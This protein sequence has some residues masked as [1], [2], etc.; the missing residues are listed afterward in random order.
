MSSLKCAISTP[1]ALATEAGERAIEEGGNA[2]D[3]ALAAATMLTV[4]YPH[5]CAVGGDMFCL[6]RRPD[7]STISIDATGAAAA[8]RTS[9]ELIRSA[10]RMPVSGVETI[11]VP[12][13]V[14]GWEALFD[15]GGRLSISEPLLAA[16]GVAS[17]G[18]AV[19][20]SLARA[21]DEH[22][23]MIDADSGMR[24]VM[25]LEGSVRGEGQTLRQPRL[26]ATL[27][28]LAEQGSAALYGGA[29]GKRLIAGLRELGSALTIE[30]LRAHR[31]DI[32]AALSRSVGGVEVATSP[33]GSQGFVLLEIM[34]AIG[35]QGI[36]SGID[37][38]LLAQ[39]FRLAARDRDRYLGDPRQVEIPVEQLLSPARAAKL[40][41]DA[42]GSLEIEGRPVL[43]HPRP[44]GDTVAVVAV[45]SEGRAVSLIQSVFH[46]FGSGILEPDT[47]II[48]HNRGA[49][50]SLDPS[51]P[52]LF[53]PGR[54]PAH[55]LMPV[56]VT[57]PDLLA[58]HGTMGGRAQPQIHTHLLLN[59]LAGMS[60]EDAV[61]SPRFVVGGLDAGTRNDIVIAEAGLETEVIQALERSKMELKI[62]ED[63]DEIVGHSQMATL[64][65]GAFDAAS[66]PRA[67]GTAVV[68]T[69]PETEGPE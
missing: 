28:N 42:Q 49:C 47:G 66:D 19:A 50:F 53:H 36:E 46:A 37:P 33:P 20:P 41:R 27:E 55:T 60:P 7:G 58:A 8:G 35:R 57:A 24:E 15:L 9:A 25:T 32:S 2:I 5:M 56:I 34:A 38:A 4:V 48:C 40:R 63:L 13:V 21:L 45:D 16:A 52:N 43:H 23:D 68:A 59:R 22:R 51:S 1:H 10:Q 18:V 39:I 65:G 26:A 62:G 54:R 44:D 17:D 12:G 30:D 67:D 29:L 6:L 3:A 61:A 31:T 11:T 14:G 64:Q 69:G